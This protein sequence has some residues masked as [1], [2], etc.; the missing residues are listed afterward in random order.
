M[1]MYHHWLHTWISYINFHFNIY[2]YT[3]LY[4]LWFVYL[5]SWTWSIS[6]I[7]F[8]LKARQPRRCSWRISWSSEALLPW[9]LPERKEVRTGNHPRRTN[10]VYIIF[11]THTHIY[12]CIYKDIYVYICMYIYI[13]VYVCI[14]IYMCVCVCVWPF[15]LCIYF[16]YF[17][18]QI[19]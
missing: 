19:L 17:Y 12:I 1:P 9:R 18:I 13:C 10:D 6:P 4:I 11:N 14:Y 3:L 15:F 2:I 5:E 16:F 8:W 7:R